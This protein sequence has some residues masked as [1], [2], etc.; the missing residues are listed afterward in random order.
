MLTDALKQTIQTAYSRMLQN[1][2]LQTRPGQK[3]MIAEIARTLCAVERDEDGRRSAPEPGVCVVEAGTGTGKTLGYLVSALPVAQALDKKLIIATAT[4]TLQEQVLQKDIPDLLQHSDLR[5]TYALAK[6]RGRYLCLA[7]LDNLLRG[8]GSADAL[9]DLFQMEVDTREGNDQALYENMLERLNGGDWQ[10]DRDAWPETIDDGAW[11]AVAVEQ[12]Q[13]SGNRCSYFSSCCYFRN[14]ND[15][16]KVDCIVANHDLVLSDLA[17]GGGVILPAPADAIYVFDEAH[18]LPGKGINHFTHSLRLGATAQWLDQLATALQRSGAQ[19]QG[20]GKLADL[21]REGIDLAHAARVTLQQTHTLLQP[22]SDRAEAVVAKGE[23][24][25]FVFAKGVV[26]DFVCQQL[27]NLCAELTS[28]AIRLEKI[29]AILK[30]C[31]ENDGGE[32]DRARA[33]SWF[34]LFGSL[35]VRV[36]AGAACCLHFSRADDSHAVPAA[37]WLVFH[38][39][40]GVVDVSLHT[41]P[42]LAADAL[43]DK[44]WSSCYG[45]VLTSATLSALGS[46]DFLAQ[47]CGLPSSTSFHRI[48]SP[49]SHQEAAVL[50]VPRQ[51]FDPTDTAGHTRAITEL[52]P[53]LLTDK[54]GALVLFS[55]RRQLLDV[56]EGLD[57]LF[58][59]QVLAQDDYAKQELLRLHRAAVNR[60]EG[61]VI[62]GLASLAEGID[63][64]GAYCTHVVIAKIPFPVPNDPV[65][66]TLGEWVKAQGRNPFQEISVPEAA[67]RLIQASGRLLRQES[68]RGTITILD[69]R[70][71]SRSYGRAILDS[72]PP[73]PREVF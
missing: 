5:F 72:L 65:D 48:Q 60:G 42:V 41:S 25:Q 32:V 55:S 45:A 23:T 11:R 40:D 27:D 26:D 67:L 13:C 16:D 50:R 2:Q 39:N 64:P 6:G 14:R 15:L 58:R 57:P 3:R 8:G 1:K 63:L 69:Q 37:R 43:Q 20:Q 10:G 4:V 71:L 46:F 17:L 33:E 30:D 70:L 29:T 34:L 18:Q 49:F 66:A 7:K 53:K 22:F 68:D 54:S 62:F 59:R 24:G 44:L 47:R 9:R 73:Y 19:L 35:E 38:D 36:A 51:G 61:S 21:L 28:L 56:L 31:L 12:G 52:L